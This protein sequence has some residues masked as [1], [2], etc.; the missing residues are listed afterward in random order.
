[1]DKVYLGDGVYAQWDGEY[2]ILTA[3]DGT[4]TPTSTIY[5]EGTVMLALIEYVGKLH[6]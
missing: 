1:M 5:L 2:V 4:P 6:A 3:E